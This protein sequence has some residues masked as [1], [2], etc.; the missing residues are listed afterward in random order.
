MNADL[1]FLIGLLDRGEPS[2]VAWEDLDGKHATALQTWRKMGFLCGEPGM[3]PVASCPHCDEGVPYRLGDRFLC[4]RC[5]SVVDH[6][7]LLLWHLDREVILRW[8]A[9]QLNI[10]G[11]MRRIEDRLWQLGTW[12]AEGVRHECFFYRAGPLSDLGKMR[13][14]AYRNLLVFFGVTRPMEADRLSCRSVS[15]LELRRLDDSLS[16][17]DLHFLLRAR[18]NVRFDADSG[19]LWVGDTVVGEVPVGC[20]EY[21]FLRSLARDLDHFVPYADLKHEVLRQTGSRD[22]MEEATFCQNLKSRI[23][24]KWIPQIDQLLTTTNKADGYRLRG[25]VE[26]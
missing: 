5:R 3:N 14:S 25:Y 13:L 24:K 23:K 26:P 22:A 12:E 16:A 11:G 10:H 6:R 17:T 15:L 18:G 7:H 4:N 9:E 19:V 8:L 2:C 21:F 1:E 20:K